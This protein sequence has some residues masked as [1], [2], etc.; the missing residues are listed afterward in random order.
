MHL[1]YLDDAGS[2]NNKDEEFLVLGGVS[3][4][5][6]QC[7]FITRELDKLAESIAPSDP[8]AVEFHASEI[9]ARRTAP[10]DKMSKEEAK[11]IIKAVLQVLAKS[12][13]TARAFAC[14]IHKSSY[15]GEDPMALAFED[16]CSRFDIYLS[17]FRAEGDRQRGLIILD[18]SVHETTLQQMARNFRTLGT[19]WGVIRNLA[20]T[21]LF[22]NSKASRLVQ[23]A[24]HIAYAVFRRYHTS[25][26]Q[27]FDLIAQKF[28]ADSGVVHGLVHK[29]RG[30][31]NCMC[32]ACLSRRFRV[33]TG[34]QTS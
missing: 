19:K 28:Y 7:D 16:L 18:D 9:F 33:Q 13:D 11:G 8:H 32:P 34:G 2:A 29:Q 15:P 24:D 25:D 3:V 12:F 26:A 30:A 22:V 21:P 27:F 23:M 17:K 14:A 6:A 5:E 31:S 20:D 10:W 1:L 4:F